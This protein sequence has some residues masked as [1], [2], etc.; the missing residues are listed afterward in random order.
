VDGDEALMAR[1]PL[2]PLEDVCAGF[3]PVQAEEERC[4]SI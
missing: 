4:R 2:S 1:T 3:A